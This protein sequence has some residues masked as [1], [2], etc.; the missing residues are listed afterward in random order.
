MNLVDI[1]CRV[2]WSMT[3]QSMVYDSLSSHFMVF[4]LSI[5]T[6]YVWD[7][8]TWVSYAD[9]YC[10]TNPES[11][12]HT[13]LP[14]LTGNTEQHIQFRLGYMGEVWPQWTVNWLF[15]FIVVLCV[16]L[17][18]RITVL[19]LL[20]RLVLD[21]L[22]ELCW[23]VNSINE[24]NVTEDCFSTAKDRRNWKKYCMMICYQK[25]WQAP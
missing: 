11:E 6:S 2:D 24:R 18:T 15:H 8:K 10:I 9:K 17:F 12:G 19:T 1:G 4:L 13:R 23:R 5:K 22:D 20:D 7:N 25:L 3:I 14:S 21:D 16:Y